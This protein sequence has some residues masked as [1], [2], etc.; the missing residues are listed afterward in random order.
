MRERHEIEDDIR[1]ASMPG[2]GA[3]EPGVR[4]QL[5]LEVL[6]DIREQLQLNRDAAAHAHAQL[7]QTL[8]VL[9]G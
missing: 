7:L 1:K 8:R 5:T 3:M 2:S 9:R 4:E 6:L